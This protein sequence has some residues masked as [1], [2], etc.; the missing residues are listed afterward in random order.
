MKTSQVRS[1]RQVQRM[2][3]S[4]KVPS[5]TR[6][7]SDSSSPDQPRTPR[8]AVQ[9]AQLRSMS[10][11]KFSDDQKYLI[12]SDADDPQIAIKQT[13]MTTFALAILFF[14]FIV[15]SN[16]V[17]RFGKDI[18]QFSLSDWWYQTTLNAVPS[19]WDDLLESVS[20]SSVWNLNDFNGSDNT[21]PGYNAATDFIVSLLALT[22]LIVWFALPSIWQLT[23]HHTHSETVEVDFLP[24]VKLLSA[25]SVATPVEEQVT[26]S[27][28]EWLAKKINSCDYATADQLL[29]LLNGSEQTGGIGAVSL[30]G[31]VL[32]LTRKDLKCSEYML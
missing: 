21:S 15:I 3:D 16:Q 27:E 25:L 8:P 1:N 13:M 4:D 5:L 12:F 14:L 23:F 32:V 11:Q 9:T 6:S 31:Q 20:Q 18:S 28:S 30:P 10:H 17:I 22:C 24:L 2:Q 7:S 29:P 19:S 26:L